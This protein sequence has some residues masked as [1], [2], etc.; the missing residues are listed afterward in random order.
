MSNDLY[1]IRRIEKADYYK[2]FL[3]TLSHLTEVGEIS[4]EQI[5]EFR[6]F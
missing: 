5:P 6:G 1:P 4:F 3:R 2:G